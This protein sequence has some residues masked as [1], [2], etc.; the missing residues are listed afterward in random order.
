MRGP[1]RLTF[2]GTAAGFPTKTRPHTSAIGLWRGSSLYLFDAGEGVAA[3]FSRMEVPPDALRAIFLTHPHADHVAGL[4]LLAQ[5]L[6]L[7]RRR[8]PVAIHV[9]DQSLAG[10][11]GCLHF[12]YLYPMTEFEIEFRPVSSG[13]VHQQDGLQ[14]TAVHS[15]HLEPGERGRARAGQRVDS[16]AFSYLI[17]VDGK[18]VYLSGDIGGPEEA[19]KHDASTAVVELAHFTAEELGAALSASSLVRLIVTHV[20]DEF[21]PFE[22]EIPARVAAMGFQGEVIVATDGLEV[23]L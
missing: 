3:Q 9:P 13:L 2:F 15:H 4:P 14:V 20:K 1:S 10:L 18:T 11:K 21:E 7:N 8:A 6:Q 23:G 12:L 19:A 5:W 16:Q 17:G 22:Q